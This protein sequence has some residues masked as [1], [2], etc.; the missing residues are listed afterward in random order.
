MPTTPALR[1][2]VDGEGFESFSV[3]IDDVTTNY[4]YNNQDIPLTGFNSNTAN[5]CCVF[6]FFLGST[7]GKHLMCSFHFHIPPR[8]VDEDLKVK[9]LDNTSKRLC[10]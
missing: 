1:F 3:E 2:S 8:S 4:G 10:I 9:L 5:A 7:D 6:K